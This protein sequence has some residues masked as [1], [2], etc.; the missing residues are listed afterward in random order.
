M[1]KCF[2]CKKR[3][4]MNCEIC[5]KY[6]CDYHLQRIICTE[7]YHLFLCPDCLKNH[8][9]KLD[10]FISM[11]KEITKLYEQIDKLYDQCDT[12]LSNLNEVMEE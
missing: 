3:D 1:P 9:D 12:W 4:V 2:Y 10:E 7:G 6:I 8:E 11:R 5:T